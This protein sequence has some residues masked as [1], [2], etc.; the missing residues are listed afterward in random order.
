[1]LATSLELS[2]SQVH[3]GALLPPWRVCA[4]TP[5]G[6]VDEHDRDEQQGKHAVAPPPATRILAVT[7]PFPWLDIQAT[8]IEV[9]NDGTNVDREW[10]VL[11]N[12]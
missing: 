8:R 12:M 6:L 1:M 5:F 9:I 7:A 10:S 11:R 2:R 3:S 4:S